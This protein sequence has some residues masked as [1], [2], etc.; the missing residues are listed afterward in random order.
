MRRFALLSLA[1]AAWLQAA[2]ITQLLD[3]L[4]K[5]P[6][7]QLDAAQAE[8]AALAVRKVKDSF[9][10]TVELFATYEHYNSPTNLR[11]MSPVES[12]AMSRDGRP[13]PFATTIER[14]GARISVPLFVK[15]LFSLTDKAEAM[16]KSARAKKR[17]NFLQNEA[18]VVGTVAS[19]RHLEALARAMAGRMR[20]IEKMREDMRI[21]VESGRAPGV[22]LDKLDA[23]LDRLRI[24]MNDLEVREAQIMARLG[25][26]T[27]LRPE[28]PA[29]LRKRAGVDEKE[30]FALKPL[31][32]AVEAK[33]HAIHAAKDTLYPKVAASAYWS[34]NYGQNAVAPLGRSGTN[35]DVH[36][37][38]GNYMVGLSMPLFAKERYTGIEQAEVALRKEQMRLAQAKQELEAQAKALRRT[39]RLT[40]RSRTLAQKSVQ[41]EEKLLAYAKVAF[42]TGRMSEEEYLRYE[43]ALLEAQSKLSE[44]EA[45]WWQA[46]AQLAVLYGNDLRDIVE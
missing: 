37:G 30:L 15:E 28:E 2:T 22:A 43:E 21:K 1:A 29:A 19:W 25:A 44:T 13:L 9:W 10:P 35:D 17:L 31:E 23:S 8:Y 7:T 41:S 34:E 26:L 3:A 24:A 45:A 11:P 4:Q 40:E 14:V 42:E 32:L 6:L 46:L 39:L 18:L 20:S 12:A 27:G 16:A 33:R 38:Y 5:Q 36:R